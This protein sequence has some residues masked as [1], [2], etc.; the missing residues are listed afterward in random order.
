MFNNSN[1]EQASDDSV[2]KI[3][4]ELPTYSEMYTLSKQVKMFKHI[5]TREGMIWDAEAI[6]KAYESPVAAAQRY[7]R[8]SAGAVM[9]MAREEERKNV[10]P[11]I[12]LEPLDEAV[13]DAILQMPNN[14]IK[15]ASPMRRFQYVQSALSNQ[16]A[17]PQTDN[18]RLLHVQTTRRSNYRK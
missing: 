9:K 11:K 8:E 12:K 14:M 17:V 15:N 7:V 1:Q 3:I 13:E 18:A 2:V 4:L 10:H 16:K 5:N 6:R